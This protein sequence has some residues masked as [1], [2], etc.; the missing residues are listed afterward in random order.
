MTEHDRPL[1][2]RLDPRLGRES[3]RGSPAR[4]S[5]AQGPNPNPRRGRRRVRTAVVAR[6]LAAVLSVV[7]LAGSG[8]GWYLARVA[9]ASVSRT[10]AIPDSGNSDV[11][12]RDHA[13]A[14]MNLLLVGM[15]SRKGLTP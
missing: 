14:E 15:D 2:P 8:W 9:D 6:S 11:N 5:S 1:P 13:G 12:G 10:D 7:L 3:R 4:G